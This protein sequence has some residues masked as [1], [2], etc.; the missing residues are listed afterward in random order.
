MVINQFSAV[1]NHIRDSVRKF[2]YV[3]RYRH[4]LIIPL[5][6]VKKLA[7]MSDNIGMFAH[8]FNNIRSVIFG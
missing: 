3:K 5:N 1:T 8:G 6:A 7:V 2:F 4:T